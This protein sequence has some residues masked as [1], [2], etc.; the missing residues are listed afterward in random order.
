MALALPSGQQEP[1]PGGID[2]M[3]F[4]RPLGQSRHVAAASSYMSMRTSPEE[5]INLHRFAGAAACETDQHEEQAGDQVRPASK[6]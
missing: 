2:V 3:R 5:G 4:D 1:A 6:G